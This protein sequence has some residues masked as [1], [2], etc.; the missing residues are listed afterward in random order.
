VKAAASVALLVAA[1]CGAAKPE[2]P[3]QERLTQLERD[4]YSFTCGDQ[5]RSAHLGKRAFFALADRERIP[6]L[7]R[8]RAA[9][10]IFYAVT[11]VCRGKPGSYKPAEAAVAGVRSGR[12]RAALGSGQ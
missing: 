12:Y 2:V 5:S 10:S 7:N 4:P 1:A 8:L 6:R 3:I 11:E 9:H